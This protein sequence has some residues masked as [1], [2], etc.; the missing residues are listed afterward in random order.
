MKLHLPLGLLAALLLAYPSVQADPTTFT[1]VTFKHQNTEL[2]TGGANVLVEGEYGKDPEDSTA[3][4]PSG[5]SINLSTATVILAGTVTFKGGA[6]ATQFIPTITTNGG[7]GGRVTIES[8]NDLHSSLELVITGGI[9][10]ALSDSLFSNGRKPSLITFDN[11]SFYYSENQKDMTSDVRIGEGGVRLNG[12]SQA[13]YVFS[14]AVTGSGNIANMLYGGESYTISFTGD[15]SQFTGTW[16]EVG[17]NESAK[18]WVF[19]AAN[20]TAAASTDGVIGGGIGR[21]NGDSTIKSK[22]TFNYTDAYTVKGAVYARK[23][24]LNGANGIA[25]FENT[26]N[27]DSLVFGAGTAKAI[28][29]EGTITSVTGTGAGI[30]K[31]GAGNL[32]VSNLGDNTLLLTGGSVSGTLSGGTI[33]AN[34][35]SLSAFTLNGGSLDFGTVAD[36]GIAHSLTGAGAIT[37]TSGSLMLDGWE[38]LASGNTYDLISTTGTLSIADETGITFGSDS[39]VV[40]DGAH[41]TYTNDSGR[42]TATFNVVEGQRLTLSIAD[43]VGAVLTWA[44]ADGATWAVDGG[45]WDGGGSFSNDSV[46]IFGGDVAKTVLISGEVQPA[47][48]DVTGTYTFNCE[49]DTENSGLAGTGT[50]NVSGSATFNGTHSAWEGFTHVENG[51][52]VSLALGSALLGHMDVAEGGVL[53]IAVDANQTISKF[54]PTGAGDV[55]INTNAHTLTLGHGAK[56]STEAE[57]AS[58]SDFSGNVHVSGGGTLRL[59]D[60]RSGTSLSISGNALGSTGSIILSGQNTTLELNATQNGTVAI[61]K[62]IVLGDG[63]KLS[64]PDGHYTM[65]SVHLTEGASATLDYNFDKTITIKE[66]VG[67]SSTD[68]LSG[69]LTVTHNDYSGGVLNITERLALSELIVNAPASVTKFSTSNVAIGSLDI[70]KGTVNFTTDGNYSAIGSISVSKGGVLQLSAV[71]AKIMC[72]DITLNAGAVIDSHCRTSLGTSGGTL[73]INAGNA[74]DGNAVIKGNYYGTLS[75]VSNITGNGTLE[76]QQCHDNHGNPVHL[77]GTISDDADGDGVVSIL[78]SSGKGQIN[79]AN[80]TYS[81]GT[82]VTGGELIVHAAN[83]VGSGEV[84]VNGGV[85]IADVANA[86]SSASK[87]SVN[88]GGLLKAT[89]SGGTA[90]TTGDVYVNAGGTLQVTATDCLGYDENVSVANIYLEGAEGSLATFRIGDDAAGNNDGNYPDRQTLRTNLYLKGNATITGNGSINPYGGSIYVSG[91]NNTIAVDIAQRNQLTL[92]VAGSLTFTGRFSRQG[93]DGGLIKTGTGTLTIAAAT[94]TENEALTYGIDHGLTVQQGAVISQRELSINDL[95]L[96]A[97]TS[98]TSTAALTLTGATQVGNG[99][100]LRLEGEQGDIA[101]ISMQGGTLELKGNGFGSAI[102]LQ[103]HADSSTSNNIISGDQSALSSAISGNGNLTLKGATGP[104]HV[105]STVSHVGDVTFESGEVN[106]GNWYSGKASLGNDGDV[107]I[108]GAAVTMCN[109]NNY[110][111]NTSISNTGDIIISG[112]SLMVQNKTSITASDKAIML[113]GGE[114]KTETTGI[115]IGRDLHVQTAAGEDIV[116]FAGLSDGNVSYSGVVM[117]ASA[118]TAGTLGNA[119]I[120]VTGDY[121]LN[122]VTVSNSSLDLSAGTLLLGTGTTLTGDDF[123]LTGGTLATVGDQVFAANATLGGVTLGGE[124]GY[125]GSITLGGEDKTL[126]FTDTVVN[127]GALDLQGKL[128]VADGKLGELDSTADADAG[129]SEGTNGFLQTQ[130]TLV[131]GTGNVTLADGAKVYIGTSDTTGTALTVSGNSAVFYTHGTTY[132][133]NA[134]MTAG[135]SATEFGKAK[136][137]YVTN[138]STLTYS[139]TTGTG[140]AGDCSGVALTLNNGTVYMSGHSIQA[141]SSV[142][143]DGGENTIKAQG[144]SLYSDVTGTGNL[145]LQSAGVFLI[146]S[147]IN[148]A[149]TLTI[150]GNGTNQEVTFQDGGSVGANVTGVTISNTGVLN[151]TQADKVD[152]NKAITVNNGKLSL[153]VNYTLNNLSLNGGQVQLGENVTALNGA[154]ALTGGDNQISSNGGAEV[155]TNVTGTGNLTVSGKADKTQLGLRSESI[156]HT[157]N[158]TLENKLELGYWVNKASRATI[159]GSNVKDVTIAEGATVNLSNKSEIMNSGKVTVNGSLTLNGNNN[160]HT[161]VKNQGDIEIAS[162]ATLAV[163]GETVSS[164]GHLENSGNIEVSG[165][166]AVNAGAVSNGGAINVNEGGEMT[167]KSGATVNST[168]NAGQLTIGEGATYSN[169]SVSATT[170]VGI[171]GLE[172]SLTNATIELKGETYSITGVKLT[173]STVTISEGTLTLDNEAL[174]SITQLTVDANARAT[175]ADGSSMAVGNSGVSVAFTGKDG[176]LA[177]SAGKTETIGEITYTLVTTD[178]LN[179]MVLNDDSRITLTLTGDIEQMLLGT[180]SVALQFD[181][182]VKA[183]AAATLRS[184]VGAS[185][186]AD[187]IFTLAGTGYTI[188]DVA[189]ND[190]N[191]VVY[192]AAAATPA[193]GVPEPTTATLSLLALAAL[194]ARRRRQK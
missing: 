18:T 155:F 151:L 187:G 146:K 119:D 89:H 6:N 47:E 129:Y 28:V 50:I 131:G 96:G 75:V 65:D 124:E 85:L 135:G 24:T 110:D 161:S 41:Y 78:V 97:G 56:S 176:G 69:S 49:P 192:I 178:Q 185:T 191:T 126:T 31:V 186:S 30:E 145:K 33:Q 118:M 156:N 133:V 152:S 48:M 90:F 141:T 15:V 93:A 121:S 4:L 165:T 72:S 113:R 116:V 34:G 193:E 81:G 88:N 137:V 180:Q 144:T 84:N 21:V 123:S 23:I 8:S 111:D 37:L 138:G 10:A 14:G 172:A 86:L 46:A 20:S 16:A 55:Y 71:D 189:Y 163:N 112:G 40:Y 35:G 80:N 166:L 148:N 51:G 11:A 103:A 101:G 179:G 17:D 9:E 5:N 87:V 74:E 42:Y 36:G 174:E 143:L 177:V 114:F 139:D 58:G 105:Y 43:Y 1:D 115:T 54:T 91:D 183:E 109:H 62:G 140:A 142:T 106:L 102:T 150:D 107:Y 132:Y 158:L 60:T 147:A 130:Y 181:G 68:A 39:Y 67:D 53:N 98:F 32:V 127:K 3:T 128:M 64:I 59:G 125:T 104:L 63:T 108:S 27:I 122:G 2:G 117:G 164:G 159:V 22:A 77:N 83:A 44:G 25:T 82:T 175:M 182:L 99:A 95:T 149:G 12:S 153:G 170:I 26:V 70:Q 171:A 157:G 79:H 188:A 120:T 194:A 134:S 160:G 13:S 92:D 136:K 94:T 173:G 7:Y 29:N 169:V 45:T 19:G 162:G 76:I 168:V 38:T 61:S 100:T 57:A 66:L 190:N 167:V 73:N 52:T 154:I 184:L